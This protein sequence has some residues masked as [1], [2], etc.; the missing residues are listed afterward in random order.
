MKDRLRTYRKDFDHSYCFGVFPTLELLRHR[1]ASA[2]AVLLTST[3]EGRPGVAMIRDL[4]RRSRIRVKVAPAQVA[5]LARNDNWCAVGVFRKY[6][7]R[8]DPDANHVVLVCPR[9][10]GNVGTI[11]RTMVG[12]GC[13]DLALVRPAPD[14]FH[15]NVVR[16]S[17]GS[18]FQASF[19]H[20]DG[21]DEYRRAHR[22]RLYAFMVNGSRAIC[23]VAFTPP[24][25]LVFGSEASGLPPEVL[26]AA[27][28]VSIPQTDGIDSLNLAMAAGIALYEATRAGSP[29]RR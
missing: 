12:F 1:P 16:S 28:S 29:P 11:L 2:V 8:L 23:D 5:R 7:T 13:R 24:F 18:V 25:S 26:S 6:R 14:V 17:M 19:E 10:M 20:F 9:Y 4:C 15:P 22:R 3:G 27:Q 21:L